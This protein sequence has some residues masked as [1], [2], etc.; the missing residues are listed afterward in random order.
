[1]RKIDHGKARK[2]NQLNLCLAL[3]YEVISNKEIKMLFLGL[4][5]THVCN[6]KEK[7][8]H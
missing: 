3:K 7:D 8:V 6:E 2:Y 4:I 5:D 1:M